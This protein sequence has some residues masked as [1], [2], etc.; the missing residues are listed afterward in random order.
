MTTLDAGPAL[1]CCACAS[2]GAVLVETHYDRHA[3]TLFRL[4]ACPG[5]GVVFSEPRQAVGA[6]WYADAVPLEAPPP[7]EDDAR[8]ESFF[9]SGLSPGRVLDVG[10]G[11]GGDRKSVV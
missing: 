2:A 4:Y 3:N 7:P 6:D 10:C 8:Y 9:R 11:E 5:C 1:S